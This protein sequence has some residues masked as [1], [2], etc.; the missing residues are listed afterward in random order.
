MQQEIKQIRGAL[1]EIHKN[2][3]CHI[4]NDDDLR[5]AEVYIDVLIRV[6][7]A[8]S[9]A[10]SALDRLEELTNKEK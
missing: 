5:S 4:S 6:Y 8:A 1:Q 10:I 9:I 3:Y 7:Y 2:T